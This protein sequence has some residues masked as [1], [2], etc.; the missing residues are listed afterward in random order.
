MFSVASPRE[1][2][3]ITLAH[4]VNEFYSVALPPILPLF[5]RE[6]AIPQPHRIATL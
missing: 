6:T 4:A 3:L 1:V 2:W 5:A